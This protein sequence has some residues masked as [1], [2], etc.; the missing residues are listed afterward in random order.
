[1]ALS[2][3]SRHQPREMSVLVKTSSAKRHHEARL[4]SCVGGA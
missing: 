2:P 4:T 3:M 1:M